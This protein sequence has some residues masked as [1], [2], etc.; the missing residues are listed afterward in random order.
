MSSSSSVGCLAAVLLARELSFLNEN[1]I[2]DCSY[3]SVGAR[4]ISVSGN[5]LVSEGDMNLS[6]LNEN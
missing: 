3:P 1:Y 2:N 5:G 4:Y 6:L